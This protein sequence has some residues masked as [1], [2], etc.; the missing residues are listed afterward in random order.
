MSELTTAARPYARAAFELAQENKAFDKWS[1][2]LEFMAA[3]AH[4][5]NMIAVLDSPRVTSE[6]GAELLISVCEERIDQQGKNFIK[7]LAEND[8]FVLLPEVAALYEFYRAEAEGK[9]DAEVVSAQEV[10]EG[11]LAAIA[12]A[13]KTRLGRDINL[14]SRIDEKL[15]G[16]AVIYAGD[17]V[18]D[19][20]VRGKLDKLSTVLTR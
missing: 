14:T 17:L 6:Q 20:S 10:S 16:G 15:L 1:E 4:D 13:L 11:Q 19:G 8:R 2:M 12:K 7:L 18:I 3:V 9:V 5:P